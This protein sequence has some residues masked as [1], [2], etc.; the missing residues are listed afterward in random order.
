MQDSIA[1]HFSSEFLGSLELLVGGDGVDILKYD[2]GTSRHSGHS[3]GSQVIQGSQS[4][5]LLSII[6]RSA[7]PP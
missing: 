2:R 5:P 7:V 3:F 4:I 1:D 6:P